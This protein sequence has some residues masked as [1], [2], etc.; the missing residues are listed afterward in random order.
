[1]AP[2]RTDGPSRRHRRS[3]NRRRTATLNA[4]LITK[5][6]TEPV[7][8]RT[9]GLSRRMGAFEAGL[10][11]QV[12]RALVDRHISSVIWFLRLCQKYGILQPPPAPPVGSGLY[13]IP[14]SW[15]ASEWK[16]MFARYGPPPWPGPRS[17]LPGDPPET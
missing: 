11:R 10:R 14:R 16:R 2:E 17:G 8:V 13:I 6:L 9:G 3:A 15:D 12:R 5:L 4:A 1:M 7:P